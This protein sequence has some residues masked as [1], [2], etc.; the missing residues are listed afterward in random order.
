MVLA[1]VEH[2]SGT[3]EDVSLET[4]TLARDVAEQVGEPLEAIAFGP[5]AEGIAAEVGEFGVVD[6]DVVADERIAT[7]APRAWGETV[8]QC[9]D[10][11]A[12]DAVLA[13]GSDRGSEML[14]HVAAKRELPMAA[15]CFDVD[16]GDTYELRRNRWGGTLIEHATLDAGTKLLTVAPNEVSAQPGGDGGEAAV[17]DFS[18]IYIPCGISG[19]VQHMVGCKGAEHIL[20]VNTDPEAAIIQKAD[21]AVVADLHE[22]VPAVAEE[23]ETRGD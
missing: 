5:E 10:A 16:A 14:A 20:A 8:N 11:L 4:L 6:L 23:L 9:I 2:D 19:A 21:W 17:H 22:V 3:V 18:E 15:T 7:Y 1:F 12:P 13:P